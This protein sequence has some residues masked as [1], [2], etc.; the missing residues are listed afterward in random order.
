MTIVVGKIAEN[1]DIAKMNIPLFIRLL[2]YAREDSK[3]DMDLHFVAE[4]IA[5]GSKNGTLSMISY[6]SIIDYVNCK[7]KEK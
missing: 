1:V 6:D 3:S 7:N 5:A 2:E 4:A